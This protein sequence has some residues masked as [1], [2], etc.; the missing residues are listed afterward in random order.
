[1]F[2]LLV[3]VFCSWRL[4][5]QN[6]WLWISLCSLSW[7][8]NVNDLDLPQTHQASYHEAIYLT[9]IYQFFSLS[10]LWLRNL[11]SS[12]SQTPSFLPFYFFGVYFSS[13]S[14]S[15]SSPHN[16]HRRNIRRRNYVCCTNNKTTTT[17][18]TQHNEAHQL[19][20]SSLPLHYFSSL[21]KSLKKRLNRK[22]TQ[23]MRWIGRRRRRDVNGKLL[24]K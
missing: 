17:T 19:F 9:H 1:M 11:S 3:L 24:C 7:I 4:C 14:S 23:N 13:Y 21:K 18:H 10:R 22:H 15:C 5:R 6:L 20:T 2:V 12:I 8:S 16:N